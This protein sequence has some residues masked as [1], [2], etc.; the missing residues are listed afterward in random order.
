MAK[1]FMMISPQL[2]VDAQ[3]IIFPAL[4]KDEIPFSTYI[5]E[6]DEPTFAQVMNAIDRAEAKGCDGVVAIGGGSVIDLAKAVSI[7]I[8]NPEQCLK[9]IQQESVIERLPLIAIPTTAGSGSEA[10]AIMAII[11]NEKGIKLDPCHPSFIPD[12][13]IV[14]SYWTQSLS[15]SITAYTGLA[16]LAQAIESF[17]S[18]KANDFSDF[19]A[20]DAIIKI[21]NN[22]PDVYNKTTNPLA[23][24]EML[25]GSLYAGISFSNSSTNLAYATG[26]AL[27]DRFQLPHGLCMALMH[28]FVIEYNLEV[29]EDRYAEIAIALGHSPNLSKADLAKRVLM[30]VRQYNRRFHIWEVSRQFIQP[31]D[32]LLPNIQPLAELTIQ[33]NDL[34]VHRRQP[35]REDIERLFE[36]LLHVF[37]MEGF[38]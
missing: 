16:A 32:D 2:M 35:S 27:G 37:V 9:T 30:L 19:Y 13:A 21:T 3:S 17:V 38:Q 29:A 20:L 11:D 10:T 4:E 25:L 24:N 5:C 18:T 14:D 34:G 36:Q 8:L 12:V 6:S 28:P 33:S 15:P 31:E 7:F 26:K 23:Y 22:L 1:P